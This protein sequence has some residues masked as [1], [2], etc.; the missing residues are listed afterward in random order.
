MDYEDDEF[1]LEFSLDMVQD[2]SI[3]NSIVKKPTR[4]KII[5]TPTKQKTKRCTDTIDWVEAECGE[6][7]KKITKGKSGY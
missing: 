7:Y 1:S 3:K 2:S 4:V 5:S 6:K